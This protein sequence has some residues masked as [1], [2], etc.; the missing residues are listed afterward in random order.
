[1]EIRDP[2]KNNILKIKQRIASVCARIGRRPEE[3]TIVAVAKNR[4]K[5]QIS[6][7]LEA[8]ITGIGENRVQEALLKYQSLRA[9]SQKRRVKWHMVGHLQTNK[10]KDAVKIFDLIHS[11]DSFHLAAEI[12]KRAKEAG[13]VQDILVEVNTSKETSKFGIMPEELHGFLNSA[14]GLNNI[15]SL[16]LMTIA[17]LSDDKNDARLSFRKLK[18]LAD[19]INGQRAKEFRLDILSMGMSDDFEEAIEEGAN[20]I[21]IGRAIFLGAGD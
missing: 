12:D 4:T 7:A 1:M 17:A 20:L 6:Q 9:V 18:Q 2:V 14:G 3:I 8:G 11:V 5:E 16:G 13:K 10:V 21:R 15:R 19:N